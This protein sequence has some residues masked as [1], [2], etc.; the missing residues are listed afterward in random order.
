MPEL[1][2]K[3][4]NL[5][6]TSFTWEFFLLNKYFFPKCIYV[7]GT[8]LKK[9]T[10][11][12]KLQKW[13]NIWDTTVQKVANWNFLSLF[14]KYCKRPNSIFLVDL[15]LYHK[16]SLTVNVFVDLANGAMP[17]TRTTLVVSAGGIR[18]TWL[19]GLGLWMTEEML[20]I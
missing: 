16:K 20:W 6:D 2:T 19:L 15:H 7:W 9:K 1:I 4:Y 13:L 17:S 11:T 8:E 3:F 14:V 18:L 5:H 10:K 12:P